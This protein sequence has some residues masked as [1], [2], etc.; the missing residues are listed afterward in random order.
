MN[1]KAIIR[2]I[3]RNKLVLLAVPLITM[4]GVAFYVKNLPQTYISYAQMA[5]GFTENTGVSISDNEVMQ[6][7][8]IQNKFSNLIELFKSKTIISLVSYSLYVHDHNNKNPFRKPKE[9][10]N[11]PQQVKDDAARVFQM[12]LDSLT[13]FGYIQDATLNNLLE[14]YGYD[15]ESIIKKLKINRNGSSDYIMATFESE[16]P[17]LSAYVVN[18]LLDQVNKYQCMKQLK[19]IAHDIDFFAMLERSKKQELQAKNDSLKRFKLK[20]N[21]LNLN[22]Q[23]TV[24][25]DRIKNL[26]IEKQNNEKRLSGI[27]ESIA[28][29]NQKFTQKDKLYYEAKQSEI[30][31][32]LT[33]LREQLSKLITKD[34]ESGRTNKAIQDSIVAIR[35]Q[36]ERE[37]DISSRDF[38]LNP[39][40][41][42]ADLV[43]RKLDLELELQQTKQNIASIEKEL[44]KQK[45]IQVSFTPY[46]AEIAAIE[47][48]IKMAEQVYLDVLSKYNQA[49][50][51]AAECKTSKYKIEEFGVPSSKPD[52][53]K[54]VIIILLSGVLSFILTLST[55]VGLVLIDGRIKSPE[56]FES[57]TGYPVKGFLNLVEGSKLDLKNMFSEAQKDRDLNFFKQQ[58]RNLRHEFEIQ[59]AENKVFLFT[60]NE[61]NEGKSL[62]IASLAYTLHLTDK[63]V[64]VIDGNL[65]NN[66]LTEIF[67]ARPMLNDNIRN[68]TFPGDL[69]TK[70]TLSGVDVVGVG[71]SGFSPSELLPEKDFKKL[72]NWA[73]EYYD[74]IFMESAA[75]NVYSDTKELTQFADKLIAVFA[76]NR[77]LTD[78]DKTTFKYLQTLD[79][80]FDGYIINKVELSEL[81]IDLKKHA[82]SDIKA[83]K[84]S[85]QGVLSKTTFQI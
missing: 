54:N 27:K 76:A 45:S 15:Y 78:A 83:S 17:H 34:I 49:K 33:K 18:T 60:S 5:T 6:P 28:E 52:Q 85:Q 81:E 55:I 48:D 16:N 46:E 65:K 69:V 11:I 62:V 59:S 63:K 43:K 74:F 8:M 19:E 73:R 37:V 41:V 36:I 31:N 64:L 71:V 79:S 56:A 2:A 82:D 21:I 84:K 24:L 23:S 58:L 22:E 39:T 44:A 12:R 40:N 68:C 13:S 29:I 1:L 20:Y 61:R 51:I 32:R 4:T 3:L 47:R 9:A 53:S 67:Q 25:I 30:N 70:T 77:A 35:A 72:I 80:K 66:T 26:E 50:L 75:L 14:V 38:D 42:K 7:Y 10:E 57:A